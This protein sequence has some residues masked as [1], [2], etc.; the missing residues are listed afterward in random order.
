MSLLA[1]PYAFSHCYIDVPSIMLD[2]QYRM[3]PT[4]SKFPATEFYD[5][6]LLD[7]TVQNTGTVMPGLAPP[8]SS[9]LVPHPETGHRPSLIF[10]DHQG[11]EAMMRRS[12]VN[13]TE[14]YIICNI[15]E[16]LLFQNPVRLLPSFLSSWHRLI[17]VVTLSI[18]PYRRRYRYN[19][20]L[21]VPRISPKSSPHQR[22]SR[23]QSSSNSPR[24]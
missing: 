2:I 8:S 7:G 15:V 3:H 10:I 21:Q 22:P 4:I 19:R 18:G 1:I 12:R 20:P 23:P 5:M 13:W 14:G 6:M 17:P 9:H 16:D 24:R 11:P